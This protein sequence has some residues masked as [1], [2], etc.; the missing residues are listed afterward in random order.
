MRDRYDD[1][2]M[3]SA[4]VEIEDGI[5]NV[6]EV[7][8]RNEAIKQRR[9]AHEAFWRG[10]IATP[11]GRHEIWDMVANG[12]HTFQTA[13]QATGGIPDNNFAWYARGEQDIGLRLYRELLRI[14]HA[15]VHQ[16]HV[17]N[18]PLFMPPVTQ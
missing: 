17:E 12:C 6:D 13:M 16:M 15:A 3:R 14:D 11:E 8:R 1:T 2:G 5:G 10:C 7:A 4:A 18:D 9:I